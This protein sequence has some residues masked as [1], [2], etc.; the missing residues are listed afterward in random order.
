MVWNG[1]PVIPR[2]IELGCIMFLPKPQHTKREILPCHRLGGVCPAC[3]SMD[4]NGFGHPIVVIGL[5]TA[6][7]PDGSEVLNVTFMQVFRFSNSRSSL[8]VMKSLLSITQLTSNVSDNSPSSKGSTSKKFISKEANSKKRSSK[9]SSHNKPNFKKFRSSPKKLNSKKLDSNNTSLGT[10]NLK[11]PSSP[12]GHYN[13]NPS[14][15]WFISND[16]N[17][18]KGF[19]LLTA[20]MYTLPSERFETFNGRGKAKA[21]DV[22]F[23]KGS[24]GRLVRKYDNGVTQLANQVYVSDLSNPLHIRVCQRATSRGMIST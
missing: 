17:L 15:Y 11:E 7:H 18:K 20:H 21:Y 4:P 8:V 3:C 10:S 14:R 22:R 24:L 9:E 13:T 16:A 19:F 12:V 2:H 5:C 1:S 6:I 23:D